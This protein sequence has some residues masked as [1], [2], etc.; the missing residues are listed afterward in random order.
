MVHAFVCEPCRIRVYSAA[1]KRPRG[2]PLCGEAMTVAAVQSTRP[3]APAASPR[4]SAEP[5]AG[6]RLGMDPPPA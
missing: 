5:R 2:C 1:P 6:L 4:P 3:G